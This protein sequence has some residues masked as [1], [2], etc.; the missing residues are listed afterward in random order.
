M[1]V[2]YALEKLDAT[3]DILT[4]H[5]GR[6]QERL[7]DAYRSELAEMDELELPAEIREGFHEIVTELTDTK[8]TMGAAT[9][10]IATQEMTDEQA[11][12]IASR[13]RDLYNTAEHLES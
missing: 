11:I 13:L 9:D 8:Y 5:P 12:E 2:D 7:W 6:I 4:T 1:T 3:L 10:K